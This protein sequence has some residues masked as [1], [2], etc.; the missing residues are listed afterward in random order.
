MIITGAQFTKL[1]ISKLENFLD[2][3]N[4]K[5]S[6]GTAMKKQSLPQV[7]IPLVP[8]NSDETTSTATSSEEA[9]TAAGM[10]SSMATSV[11]SDRDLATSEAVDDGAEKTLQKII[12]SYTGL[13]PAGIARDA[14]ISDLG[15][16]SL[17]AVELA[18]ELHTVRQGN[19]SRGSS[20]KQLRGSFA[21][22][23]PFL[24]NQKSDV[25]CFQ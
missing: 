15:V 21:T 3:A 12:A 11:S 18:E 23:C 20:Y 5:P 4:A 19:H 8:I 10:G 17:A 1:L 13:A 14:D 9:E 24:L 2:S 22:T 16:D 25:A 6:Q 7:P